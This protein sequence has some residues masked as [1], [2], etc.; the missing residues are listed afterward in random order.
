MIG[1]GQGG[2]MKKTQNKWIKNHKVHI[3]AAVIVIVMI[4]L[5]IAAALF[6]FGKD[7][8]EKQQSSEAEETA[9][10]VSLELTVIADEYWTEDSSPA[11]VHIKGT[12]EAAEEIDFYHAVMPEAGSTE[13]ADSVEVVPG[14]YE[15]SA[16]TP[17]NKDGSIYK[18]DDAVTVDAGS[19]NKESLSV[20]IMLERIKAENVTDEQLKDLIEQTKT[21]IENG[22]D[23]LKGEAG[24]EILALVEK[25]VNSNPNASGETK[26]QAAETKEKTDTDTAP[27]KTTGSQKPS[28]DS[29]SG[30][31]SGSTPSG[32]N[33]NSGSEEGE[34]QH[35]WQA[36]QVW[37]PN[38]VTVVDVPEQTVYGAQLYTQQ[39]DGTWIGNGETYWFENGFTEDD[40]KAIIVDKIRNE[41]YIGSYVNR[42]K[43]I[44][45]VTHTEDHGS[46][47]TD[48]YY[49]EC[50]ERK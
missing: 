10:T 37:V 12:D 11:I 14:I 6:L 2:E 21:A 33:G 45:A 15:I 19:E 35:N 29:S 4:I 49:C 46:Y 40:L 17:I 13:V 48:Y 23:S 50:G 9:G 32:E 38:I 18:T 5:I 22:D 47:Q 26:Q 30:S 28:S 41:G 44:P 16:I 3:A 24:K 25:N 42:E 8:G 39:A 34:H 31:S 20:D 7:D 43:T 1:K 27:V 36:H